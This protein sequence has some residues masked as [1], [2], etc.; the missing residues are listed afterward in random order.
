MCHETS[1]GFFYAAFVLNIR[2]ERSAQRG[3]SWVIRYPAH[4]W[5]HQGRHETSV[6]L[7]LLWKNNYFG[8][9]INDP[10]AWTSTTAG[11]FTTS[12]GQLQA[13]FA[14]Y[15]RSLKGLAL[16][17]GV[18]RPF[19]V[20]RCREPSSSHSQ[21]KSHSGSLALKRLKDPSARP[22]VSLKPS[23]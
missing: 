8:A 4:V 22:G 18:S 19:L 14:P 5:G 21:I 3:S 17:K 20:R 9:Y 23:P 13:D 12:F 6:R 2:N 10:K 15:Y 7:L 11:E 1:G 16:R